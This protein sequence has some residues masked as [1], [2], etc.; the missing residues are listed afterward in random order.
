LEVAR[1]WYPD[2]GASVL[3]WLF[4]VVA[5]LFGGWLYLL[6]RDHVRALVERRRLLASLAIPKQ[7]ATRAA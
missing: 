7:V 1:G 5:A 2:T 3:L 6:Q 4:T